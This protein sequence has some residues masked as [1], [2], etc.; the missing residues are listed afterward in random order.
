MWAAATSRVSAS[1]ITSP[2]SV[3]PLTASPVLRGRRAAA[4]TTTK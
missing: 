4:I 2:P 3:A 1:A